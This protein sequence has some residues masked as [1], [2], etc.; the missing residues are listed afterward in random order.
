MLE[1]D[2]TQRLWREMDRE[3]RACEHRAARERAELIEEHQVEL[4]DQEVRT[5]TQIRHAEE[6]MIATVREAERK[7][8]KAV[9]ESEE[10]CKAQ[11]EA[12]LRVKA[13][14]DERFQLEEKALREEL[15]AKLLLVSERASADVE[16]ERE[17]LRSA[18]DRLAVKDAER[19]E[20]YAQKL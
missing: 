7:R 3:L 12:A 18:K 8:D 13:E 5:A 9:A 2:I 19:G 15:D 11:L 16:V 17:K 14:N 10:V 6:A 4:G 20:K 1:A